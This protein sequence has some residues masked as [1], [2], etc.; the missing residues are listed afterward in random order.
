[1]A[2]MIKTPYHCTFIHIPK[3][4]GNSITHWLQ[5]HFPTQST[6]R[7]QHA[8]LSET[9]NIL[10]NTGWT[11]C[12]VRNPWDYAVSWYTFEIDV[13]KVRIEMVNQN[14]DLSKIPKKKYDV[15][16]QQSNIERL[17]KIGFEGWLHETKRYSQSYWANDCDHIIKLENINNDFKK[18]QNK[19]NCFE[20]LPFL[21]KTRNKKPY[22]DYYTSDLLIKLVNDLWP[23][24]VKNFN[25]KF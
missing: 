9:K 24:D 23:E 1:M 10:G 4:G 11:F 18:V 6:K 25:Y 8:T 15:K 5:Q 20:P 3:T 21:N 19:L 2:T 16:L 17:E 7:N 13:A 22:R 14:P 12:T